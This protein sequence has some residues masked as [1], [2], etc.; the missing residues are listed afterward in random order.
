MP[1][2]TI[3]DGQRR[4]AERPRS[5][6]ELLIHP[7]CDNPAAPRGAMDVDWVREHAAK[8]R[9]Y[10]GGLEWLVDLTGLSTETIATYKQAAA[11]EISRTNWRDNLSPSVLVRQRLRGLWGAIARQQYFEVA[12]G[13]PVLFPKAVLFIISCEL[14][15]QDMIDRR[16]LPEGEQAFASGAEVYRHMAVVPACWHVTNFDRSYLSSRASGSRDFMRDLSNHAGQARPEVFE[17][18]ASGH[19]VTYSTADLISQFC[20]Q[21]DLAGSPRCSVGRTALGT[22]QASPHEMI[23]L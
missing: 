11:D 7:I 1:F 4:A 5:A 15:L 18:M 22:K 6:E 2:A 19:T 8:P 12:K 9:F 13:R 21:H 10:V 20:S 3:I 23:G 16:G 14:A 17:D